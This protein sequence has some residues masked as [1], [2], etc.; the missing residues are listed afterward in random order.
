MVLYMLIIKN[1]N[2]SLVKI[3]FAK[4]KMNE[5]KQYYLPLVKIKT[6]GKKKGK[7]RQF[8]IYIYR[9]REREREGLKKIKKI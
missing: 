3:S 4:K 1:I 9:E 8:H 6:L 2:A 5:N 7:K